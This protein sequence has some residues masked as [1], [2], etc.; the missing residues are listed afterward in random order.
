VS[1]RYLVDPDEPQP[2]DQQIDNLVVVLLQHK[3]DLDRARRLGR[4]SRGSWLPL[5]G[6][7]EAPW[8]Q[9][10]PK[11]LLPVLDHAVF[12]AAWGLAN[13]AVGG[14]ERSD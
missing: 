14:R 1:G 3:P 9:R 5:T 2:V 11:V 4:P 13:W 6:V 8:A 10:T 12:G 7:H